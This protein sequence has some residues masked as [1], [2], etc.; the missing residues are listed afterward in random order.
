M[1]TPPSAYDWPSLASRKEGAL[2][3]AVQMRGV[4][5]GIINA[6]TISIEMVN[7]VQRM[8]IEEIAHTG[9]RC[10]KLKPILKYK[11]ETCKKHLLIQFSKC[12]K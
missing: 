5:L 7:C 8:R 2:K 9:R 11:K 12:Q 3:P 1:Q 6:A 10:E 4:F